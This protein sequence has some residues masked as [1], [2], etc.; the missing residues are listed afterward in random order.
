ME[1][2]SSNG[3][4]AA[5]YGLMANDWTPTMYNFGQDL[6]AHLGDF[7]VKSIM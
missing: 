2:A 4:I 3:L 6:R 1:E 5:K 7:D